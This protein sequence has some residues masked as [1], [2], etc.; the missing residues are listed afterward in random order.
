[1]LGHNIT[2]SNTATATLGEMVVDEGETFKSSSY[3]KMRW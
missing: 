1:L 3:P 2:Q